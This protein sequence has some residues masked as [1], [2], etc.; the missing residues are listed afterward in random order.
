MNLKRMGNVKVKS[1]MHPGL[2]KGLMICGS[3]L[4]SCPWVI[5]ISQSPGF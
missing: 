3:D 4:S 1:I 5:I 2:S